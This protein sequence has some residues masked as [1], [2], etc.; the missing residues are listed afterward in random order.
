MQALALNAIVLDN[1]ART[2]NNLSRVSLPV[3]LAETRPGT[4]DFGV[5]D[6]DK[7]D[8][9]LR[10]EGFDQLDILC[11]GASLN[12]DAKMSL[13]FVEGLGCL[14]EASRETIVD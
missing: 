2:P 11:F 9:V 12:E 10:A 14:T 1:N 8:L 3:D 5:A 7:V 6:L 4:E 13:T